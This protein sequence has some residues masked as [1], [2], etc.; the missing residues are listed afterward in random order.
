MGDISMKI[1]KLM[2]MLKIIDN[3]IFLGYLRNEKGNG[4]SRTGRKVTS[5][6]PIHDSVIKTQDNTITT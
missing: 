6:Q 1:I 3:S 5:K 2:I 4:R